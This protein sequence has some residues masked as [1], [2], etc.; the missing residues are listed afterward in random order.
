[1]TFRPGIALGERA[2]ARSRI[3]FAAGHDRSRLPPLAV[4]T[5]L[6]IWNESRR[7]TPPDAVA[8]VAVVADEPGK[9]ELENPP[10]GDDS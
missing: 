8:L 5:I 9:L 1:V 2:D 6:L 3:A 4:A 10:S 7:S